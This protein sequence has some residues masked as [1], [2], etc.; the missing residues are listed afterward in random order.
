ML[1]VRRVEMSLLDSLLLV[2]DVSMF[3]FVAERTSFS[4]RW[5]L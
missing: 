4:L 1:A 2:D 5:G 3:F